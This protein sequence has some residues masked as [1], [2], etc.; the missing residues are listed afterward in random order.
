MVRAGVFK[1]SFGVESANDEV[2]KRAQKNLDLDKV[3]SMTAVARKLGLIV[4]GNFMFGL[5][6]ETE[7]TM[8]ET[9]AFAV[10]M[11][12]H[13]ANFMITVPLPG[14][15]LYDELKRSG[16]LIID[17]KEGLSTGFY[18]PAVYYR[19]PGVE[20]ACILA[21]YRTAYFRFYFR[22]S[23]MTDS[24][25]S[26]RSFPELLWYATAV[27]DTLKQVGGRQ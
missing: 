13:I 15:A 25:L 4:I 21:R 11:N 8:N 6:G 2:R 10:R 7:A 22:L 9:I 27:T 23:K 3:L 26:I 18:A 24:L 19:L 20:P 1:V 12:P 16:N 17:T 5:P 14:T